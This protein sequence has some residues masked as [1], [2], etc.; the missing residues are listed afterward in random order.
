MRLTQDLDFIAEK[1]GNSAIKVFDV[2][3]GTRI[4]KLLERVKQIEQPMTQEHYLFIMQMANMLIGDD[5]SFIHIQDLQEKRAL[6][7]G[8]FVA[9]YFDGR[10][11]VVHSRD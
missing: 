4:R 5:H 8:G 10:A 3:A 11:L 6:K 7:Y 1:V 2:N 9:T